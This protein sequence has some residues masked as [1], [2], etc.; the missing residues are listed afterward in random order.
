MRT[1]LSDNKVEEQALNC[2]HLANVSFEMLQEQF[3]WPHFE[4]GEVWISPQVAEALTPDD[5]NNALH[6]HGSGS[7]GLLGAEDW[8][9]NDY[10]LN[11]KMP[12]LSLYQGEDGTMFMICTDF[13][14]QLTEV[15]LPC[16][17]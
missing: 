7:W 9:A 1:I 5:V 13:D 16:E 4:L 8:K 3:A 10:C 14:R 11:A 2:H 12:I 17:L 15:L 6:Q